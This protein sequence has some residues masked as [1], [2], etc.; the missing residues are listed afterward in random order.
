LTDRY[1]RIA[2]AL[3]WIVA[4]LILGAYIAIYYSN[5]FTLKG[6]PE[7]V[8][9]RQLHIAFGL[10]IGLFVV[11]RIIWRLTHRPP[12]LPPGPAW[13][14]VMARLSHGLLYFFIIAMP[15]TGYLGTKSAAK[16]LVIVPGF[17][18]TAL[19][20][21]LVTDTLGLTWDGW[22]KPL[23]TLHYFSGANLVWVLILLHVLAALYHQFH[24]RDRLMRR[25]W[26]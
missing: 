2:V 8:V 17:P 4:L 11:L 15:L 18:S 26:F 3:H 6:T 19:Y 20:R 22:R 14:H 16:Y 7:R 23:N 5:W 13:Q 1:S 9:S 21:W 24:T 12:A 25:M 10:S